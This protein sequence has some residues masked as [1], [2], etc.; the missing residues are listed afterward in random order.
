M[1]KKFVAHYCKNILFLIVLITIN[2]YVRIYIEDLKTLET[3][4]KGYIESISGAQPL[5]NQSLV[6]QEFQSYTYHFQ[7]ETTD[8]IASVHVQVS[9]LLPQGK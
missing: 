6:D 2:D 7:R 9:Q 5:L 1:I 4:L 3:S 8:K